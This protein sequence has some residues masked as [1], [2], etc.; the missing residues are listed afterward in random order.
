MKCPSGGPLIQ[1][2]LVA[3]MEL[4]DQG[5]FTLEQVVEKMCHAPARLFRIEK[6]GFIREDFQA[7]LVLV[8]TEAPWTV[9]D[10]NILYKC[11]WSPFEGQQFKAR[12]LN[13]WV[14]GEMVFAN[15]RVDHDARG[16]RILFDR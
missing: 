4:A 8:D 13:T 2:S 14:N 12:V 6:R 1:H 9:S 16:Q 15:G 11:R 10:Q 5:V 3:M 7:D